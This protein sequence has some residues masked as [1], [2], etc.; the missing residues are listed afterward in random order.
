MKTSSSLLQSLKSGAVGL[1]LAL[2]GLTMAAPSAQ[3]AGPKAYRFTAAG[4]SDTLTIN[5]AA[6]NGKPTI[7]PIVTQFW[8]GVYNN[9]P[10]GVRYDHTSGR[11]QIVN[12]DD[13][14]IP[15]NAKFN[16]LLLPATKMHPVSATNVWEHISFFQQQKNK[17]NALF[18]TTHIVNPVKGLPDLQT[19]K[20]Y[21]LYY[22]PAS[23][24]APAANRWSIYTEDT[25]DLAPV[26]FHIADVTKFKAGG[27]QAAFRYI[28]APANISGNVATITNPLTDG[29]P[30]AMV[31]ADH[32]YID[33]AN[34]VYVTKE[35]GVYYELG[36]WHLFTQDGTNFTPNSAFNIAVVPAATP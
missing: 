34:G 11:W 2:L 1:G 14:N 12:E 20:Q 4:G 13:V 25:S 15:L 23:V 19:T 30:A 22:M 7:K 3:A 29:K 16:V 24:G 17:P 26:A 32:I 10:I 36:K 28:A 27:T 35:L 5:H 9:H 21:G 6:F 31:F 18:L 33:G 8:D